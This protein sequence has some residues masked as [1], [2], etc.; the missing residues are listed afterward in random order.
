[1]NP[2]T[3]WLVLAAGTALFVG[4]VLRRPFN[5]RD[6]LAA[7]GLA[8]VLWWTGAAEFEQARVAAFVGISA[9]AFALGTTVAFLF[10][11]HGD[12]EQS[13]GKVRDWL[14]GGLTVLT[15]GEALNRFQSIKALIKLFEVKTGDF[16]SLV[17]M[18]AVGLVLGFYTMFFN[19]EL[20]LN[21]L[22]K[23]GHLEQRKLTQ[24][25]AAVSVELAKADS[26][27]PDTDPE[28]K[29]AALPAEGK[30]RL[31][32]FAAVGQQA[33][34]MGEDLKPDTS[35]ALAKASYH[36]G[37]YEKAAPLLEKFLPDPE[38]ATEAALKLAQCYGEMGQPGEAVRVLERAKGDHPAPPVL[39]LLG[40]YLLWIPERLKEAVAYTTEY[41]GRRPKDD[42]AVL[43]LACAHAQLYGQS[44]KKDEELKKHALDQ[45]ARAIELDPSTKALARSLA[46]P[47]GDFV[48]LADEPKFKELV[49]S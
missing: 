41:L 32:Q 24:E 40:Y 1:M 36:S 12:E 15:F 46:R 45:L 26:L 34:E 30:K 31:A 3:V 28:A 18:L 14:L 37:Q 44:E 48:S 16:G 23:R 4:Y 2:W 49:A 35:W 22:L 33:R 13:V 21:A 10:T 42:G 29:R 7:T 20:V 39:K 27:R 38:H 47:G 19:R 43:N 11:S 25:L 17:A 8:S 9:L 5:Q 6:A